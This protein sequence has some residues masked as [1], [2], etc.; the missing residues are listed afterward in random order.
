M[1][2]V[3]ATLMGKVIKLRCRACGQSVDVPAAGMSWVKS[4]NDFI[5]RHAN[6]A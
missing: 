3:N 4:F 6:H 5:E 2:Q 1:H